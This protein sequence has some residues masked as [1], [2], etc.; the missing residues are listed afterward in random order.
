L[1][2]EDICS[3]LDQVDQRK[4]FIK[5]GIE[6][7]QAITQGVDSGRK[8]ADLAKR[9]LVRANLRLV[10]SIAKNIPTGGFK[11][12]DLIQEGNIGLNESRG[13]V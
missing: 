6:D 4:S 7:L 9:E 8:S 5:G 10:V 3:V 12:L 11:F 13:Q 2:Y 1:L